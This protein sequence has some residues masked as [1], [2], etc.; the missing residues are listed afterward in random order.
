MPAGYPQANSLQSMSSQSQPAVPIGTAPDIAITTGLIGGDFSNATAL[1]N[2]QIIND[3]LAG[4][5]GAAN[6]PG[7]LGNLYIRQTIYVP[8]DASLNVG[9]GTYLTRVPN[10]INYPLVVNKFS[11]GGAYVNGLTIA[12]GTFTVPAPGHNRNVGDTVYMEGFLGNTSLNGT[13][14]ITAAVPG[15]SFSFAAVGTNPTNNAVQLAFHSLNNVLLGSQLTRAANVVTVTEPGHKRGQ[16]DHVYIGSAGLTSTNSF[17]GAQ[18]ILSITEGVSWTYANTGANETAGGQSVILGDRNIS[19]S[20]RL[21]GNGPNVT[22][23]EWGA[24]SSLWMNMSNS[25]VS[26]MD[27]KNVTFG[28]VIAA[29]NV[30]DL[31][32]PNVFSSYNCA[33]GV[34]FDS[35]CTRCRVG[36]VSGKFTD[37]CVAW[38]VTSAA[39]AFGDTTAPCGPGNMGTLYVENVPGNSPT[40]LCKMYATAGYDAGSVE[41][42]SLTG[43]GPITL[44]D[45]TTG[46]G[47]GT[48][49]SFKAETIA[50]IPGVGV[51]AFQ[52]GGGGSWASVG[53][54]TIGEFIDN[55]AS[56]GDAGYGIA[57]SAT[58]DTF[59]INKLTCKVNRTTAWPIQ[60]SANGNTFRVDTLQ[61]KSGSAGIYQLNSGIVTNLHVGSGSFT[62]SAANTGFIV[63][64][65]GGF[66]S[67]IFYR[68]LTVPAAAALFYNA[69]SAGG[70][71]NIFMSNVI[72]DSFSSGVGGGGVTGTYNIKTV[73]CTGT[74]IGNNFIQMGTAG[75]VCRWT[76]SGDS[77][78][79]G[80]YQLL[81]STG[82]SSVNGAS[83]KADFGAN[84]AN[85]LTY[86]AGALSGDQ[87]I[88]TNATG[89]GIYTY[90]G[91]STSWALTQA[92]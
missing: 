61:G 80:R 50:N 56:A 58:F 39:G 37:D 29:F 89:P 55:P 82:T 40:A 60:L 33:V 47:G 90:K 34:Q 53:N 91:S 27:A 3:A 1:R 63:Y 22:I 32:T 13:K 15:V 28:R 4:A 43:V 2:S 72:A 36:T 24:H 49:T 87:V 78:Q 62:G 66:A 70:T 23:T 20:L 81:G 14:V 57:V 59:R 65:G 67:N 6:I 76:T 77:M 21:N 84:G 17:G 19:C 79:A 11:Q 68:D 12:N 92:L 48:F 18:E 41:V 73:N 52:I 69:S 75:Q 83:F 5:F 31:Y 9:A 85:L 74:G 10:T 44:G 38:G 8:S 45:S 71:W 30:E 54:I 51:T 26:A 25:T 46:V 42:K 7:G 16:G 88:N 35:Y 64:A 86:L